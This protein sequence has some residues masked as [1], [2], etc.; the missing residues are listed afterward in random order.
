[1]PFP[2]KQG[3]RVCAIGPERRVYTIEASDPEKKRRDSTVVVY[4]SF[5]PVLQ[6]L[7]TSR[8]VKA[9]LR[10]VTDE[11]HMLCLEGMVG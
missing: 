4:T 5:F 6:Q 10:G 3:K 11:V 7:Q 1:M 8:L 9:C 2:G